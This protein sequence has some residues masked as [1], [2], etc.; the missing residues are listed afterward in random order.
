MPNFTDPFVGN[1]PRK[2]TKS[3]LVRALRMN[4]AAELDATSL[5]EAHADACDD[6]VI[7]KVLLDVANEERVHVGE[8]IEC[9]KFLLPD[10]EAW[11]EQGYEEVREIA[12]EV[13]AGNLLPPT[14]EEKIA[15]KNES[16]P[17]LSTDDVTIGSLKEQ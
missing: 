4:V 11:I 17:S 8:F 5:Y 2:F 7:K 10:E 9:I 12:E 14:P 16:E 1:V 6:P 15:C 13:A 3:E